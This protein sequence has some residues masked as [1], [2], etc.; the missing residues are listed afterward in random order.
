[1]SIYNC[2]KK[3]LLRQ[4]L[5]FAEEF[6]FLFIYHKRIGKSFMNSTEISME[7]MKEI[8][9]NDCWSNYLM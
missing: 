3:E 5:F 9:Y 6:P 2:I 1:M 4:F 8:C 7:I